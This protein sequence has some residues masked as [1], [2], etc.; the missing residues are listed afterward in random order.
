MGNRRTDDGGDRVKYQKSKVL[1]KARRID[2]TVCI[3]GLVLIIRQHLSFVLTGK[4][5]GGKV[6]EN[7]G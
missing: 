1:V 6:M 2:S 5:G 3:K 4:N 7:I